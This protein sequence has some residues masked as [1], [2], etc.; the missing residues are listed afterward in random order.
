[1]ADHMS[2]GVAVGSL[3]IALKKKNYL[4]HC[5]FCFHR[6]IEEILRARGEEVNRG[7]NAVEITRDTPP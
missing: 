7:G 3:Y 4:A 1:M 2:R 5:M 6:N